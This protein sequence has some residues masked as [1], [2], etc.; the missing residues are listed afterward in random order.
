VKRE[1][2]VLMAWCV[3]LGAVQASFGLATEQVG[4][5]KPERPTGAQPSWPVG[6]V[7]VPRHACRVYSRWCNGNEMFYFQGSVAE[8]NELVA[9]FGR[10]RM[11]AH[12]IRVVP[13]EGKV[14]P[15]QGLV[16][17]YEYNVSLQIVG[18]IALARARR[19]P[20]ERV[21]FPLEPRLTVY[22]GDDPNVLERL[23]WPENAIIDCRVEG[24]SIE[25][26]RQ[27]PERRVYYGRLAFEDGLSAEERLRTVATRIT[28]WEKGIEGGIGLARADREGRFSALFSAGELAELREGKSWLTVTTGNW[29]IEP[30]PN[31]Q[32]FPVERLAA[33]AEKVEAVKAKA[34]TYYYGRILFDDGSLPVLEP[35]PWGGAEISVGFS[36]AGSADLDAEGYFVVTFSDEQLEKLK[37]EKA[38]KNVYV[39]LYEEKNRCRALHVYPVSL[40]GRDKAHAGLLKIPRPGPGPVDAD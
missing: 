33:K 37:G 31:G 19:E 25:S 28:L 7:E 21:N 8:I 2:V 3:L 39:P 12:E 26:K 35:K 4:P 6:I 27:R 24:V 9:L 40:L 5:D 36:Y 14:R 30:D 15:F 13:G 38:R 32:R 18:G 17:E 11:R 29:L 16:H 1:N 23:E 10:A 20:G 22:A 34:P